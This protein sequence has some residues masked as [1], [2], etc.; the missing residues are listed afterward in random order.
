M[1]RRDMSSRVLGPNNRYIHTTFNF[2]VEPPR[3][4][5]PLV[6]EGFYW[7]SIS[8]FKVTLFYDI[9]NRLYVV[10]SSEC[11]ANDAM[12]LEAVK[13][14]F[15]Q[16]AWWAHFSSNST[17]GACDTLMMTKSKLFEQFNK[18]LDQ[19]YRRYHEKGLV[20]FAGSLLHHRRY[21]GKGRFFTMKW[22]RGKR[23][24]EG[25]VFLFYL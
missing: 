12:L 23:G 17:R 9:Y 18:L 20:S 3:H 19:W 14:S 15:S 25:W 4:C 10:R 16:Q 6:F 24:E 8:N 22:L 21:H 7:W 11:E 13:E 2:T 5:I 1:T